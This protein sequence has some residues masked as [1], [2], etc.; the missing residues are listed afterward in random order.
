MDRVRE[1]SRL[2]ARSSRLEYEKDDISL[3]L[4]GRINGDINQLL[5]QLNSAPRMS[6]S[7]GLAVQNVKLVLEKYDAGK[8][9]LV[10]IVDAIDNARQA[11]VNSIRERYGFYQTMT[12]LVYTIGWPVRSGFTFRDEFM[13][14]LQEKFNR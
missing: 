10:D 12:R 2:K 3:E 6:L 4:M 5:A 9:G 7:A 13:I 1:H 14:R 11:E 8:L